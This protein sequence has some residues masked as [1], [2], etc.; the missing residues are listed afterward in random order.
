MM[1]TVCHILFIFFLDVLCYV[2]PIGLYI[3]YLHPGL[4]P[5]TFGGAPLFLFFIWRAQVGL[6]LKLVLPIVG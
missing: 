5:G 6:F 1:C 2:Y 4:I 3:P